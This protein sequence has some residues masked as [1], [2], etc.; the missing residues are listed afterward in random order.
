MS[1]MYLKTDVCPTQDIFMKKVRFL[2]D[3]NNVI[4]FTFGKPLLKDVWYEIEINIKEK[5]IETHLLRQ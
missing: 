4:D 1:N 5:N 3:E 2:D